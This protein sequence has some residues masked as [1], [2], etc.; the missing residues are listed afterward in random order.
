MLISRDCKKAR[1][2]ELPI[3]ESFVPFVS[4]RLADA[5]QGPQG[6]TDMYTLMVLSLST[7]FIENSHQNLPV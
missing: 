6:W 5:T 1:L 7:K 3:S 4:K 2:S